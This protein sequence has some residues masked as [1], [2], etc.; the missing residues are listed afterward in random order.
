MSDK[1]GGRP[2]I[3]WAVAIF[4][5]ANAAATIWLAGLRW[6][7][8]QPELAVTLAI[9][10]AGGSAAYGIN[11]ARVKSKEIEVTRSTEIEDV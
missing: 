11:A 7:E 6:H 10:M 4:F 5:G 8:L 1:L 3:A 9:G 2:W